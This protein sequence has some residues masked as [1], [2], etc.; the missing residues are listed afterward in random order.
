M[1]HSYHMCTTQ[2]ATRK[3]RVCPTTTNS[4]AKNDAILA[5]N[6]LKTVFL[7]LC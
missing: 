3:E 6:S 4:N 5:L 1:Q 7:A 2:N